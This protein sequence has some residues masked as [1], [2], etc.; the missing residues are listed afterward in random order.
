MGRYVYVG[1]WLCVDVCACVCVCVRLCAVEGRSGEPDECVGA[2]K[3]SARLTRAHHYT[4]HSHNIKRQKH[5]HH[6]THYEG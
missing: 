4:T 3:H 5:H 1:V 6:N 2:C